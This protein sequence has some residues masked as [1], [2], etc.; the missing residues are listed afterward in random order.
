VADAGF[1]KFHGALPVEE[2]SHLT[3]VGLGFDAV[4]TVCPPGQKLGLP[5]GNV[6]LCANA[7]VAHKKHKSMKK[8]FRIQQMLIL[9]KNVVEE[10]SFTII[11]N[12]KGFLS[13]F[14]IYLNN[15]RYTTRLNENDERHQRF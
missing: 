5:P 1:N 6:M 14:S 4:K 3:T 11:N 12:I 13:Y 10:S 7:Q 2:N 15:Y 8:S 9:I